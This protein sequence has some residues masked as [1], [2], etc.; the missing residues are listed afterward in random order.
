MKSSCRNIRNFTFYPIFLIITLLIISSP[1]FSTYRG[2][3][4]TSEQGNNL[5]LYNDYYALVI[6]VSNYEKW[7]KLP[8]ATKDAKDVADKLRKIGFRVQLILDPSSSELKTSLNK[9]V[10]ETGS[11][12]NRAIL[13]YYAGHGE[14]E[15]L[16][17]NTKMGYI[18]PRDCPLLKK[19][20]LGFAAHAISMKDIESVSLRIKSKHVIMLFDSCFSGS[21]FSLVR[22]LPENITEK[23]SLPVR[24][25]ITAG[26]EDEQVPDK[27]MFKRTFLIGL[28]GDA[29]L[30][31]DGYI[32]GSELGMFLSEKVVN[33]TR[34]KQHPQYGKINNP[35]LDRGDFIFAPAKTAPESESPKYTSL[36]EDKKIKKVNLIFDDSI[37]DL[38]NWNIGL[39][40]EG[41]TGKGGFEKVFIDK[42]EGANGSHVS[43][44][45]VFKLG[46]E[47]V[48]KHENRKIVAKIRND[49]NRNL[50]MYSGIDFFIKGTNGLKLRFQVSD[51]QDDS[52]DIENWY[53][54]FILTE[55][56]NHMRIEFNNLSLQLGKAKLS[57]TNMN[58][59]LDKIILMAWIIVERHN[60]SG[61]QGKVW[62]DKIA[63]Y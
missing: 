13:I 17:D 24:Q 36:K 37:S 9:L 39:K 11:E 22:A 56:W 49:L 48:K 3:H 44:A 46:L 26:N 23:S 16:A 29:D 41:R 43:I 6:G 38:R 62:I 51:K 14:T 42:S 4:I 20:P 27:S 52:K 7:P 54:D 30:T 53:F 15:T 31:G 33:Y 5:F 61:A 58:L 1:G 57:N 60:E 34:G 2:I 50:S 8:Y 19:E 18:I 21:L 35:D 59:D 40:K 25:F 28:E 47:R 63:F 10:Y 32:T 55:N 12:K 45:L